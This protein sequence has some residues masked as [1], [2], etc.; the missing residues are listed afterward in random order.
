MLAGVQ[1]TGAPTFGP[2]EVAVLE[3][4]AQDTPVVYE[5]VATTQSPQE[6]NI[7]AR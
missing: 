6:V 1:Q 2:A 3:V 7:V 5:F 4:V